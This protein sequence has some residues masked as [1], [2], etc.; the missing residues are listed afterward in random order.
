M[1]DEPAAQF[2]LGVNT[3]SEGVCGVKTASESGVGDAFV[4]PHAGTAGW[5]VRG[6]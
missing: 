3:A 6:Q 2:S 4:T 5:P 1:I